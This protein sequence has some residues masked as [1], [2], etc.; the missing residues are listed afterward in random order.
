MCICASMCVCVFKYVHIGVC[1]CRMCLFAAVIRCYQSQ[2]WQC[3]YEGVDEI[4]TGDEEGYAEC[5]SSSGQVS[6]STPSL[7]LSSLSDES[8]VLLYL[9]LS[10]E[11][12]LMATFT[13]A[14][15]IIVQRGAW[16]RDTCWELLLSTSTST[17]MNTCTCINGLNWVMNSFG[18]HLFSLKSIQ[19]FCQKIKLRCR[20]G[21]CVLSN[22]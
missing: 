19:S 3:D 1:L 9:S 15:V 17:R 14:D 6:F 8:L 5:V 12:E 22:R 11:V 7:Q 4:R 13:P 18:T 16:W 21:R 10:D 20:W 2:G